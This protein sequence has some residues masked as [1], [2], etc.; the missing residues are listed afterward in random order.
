MN[1]LLL[2]HAERKEENT[3]FYGFFLN[4]TKTSNKSIFS[5]L[6]SYLRL[7][8]MQEVKIRRRRL[9]CSR[10]CLILMHRN[11]EHGRRR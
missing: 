1:L 5:K 4:Q 2:P 7:D 9:R 11:D 3:D 6:K 10:E 8:G